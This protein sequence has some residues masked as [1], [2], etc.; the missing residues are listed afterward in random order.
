MKDQVFRKRI[1]I[2]VALIILVGILFVQKLVMIQLVHGGGYYEDADRQYRSIGGEDS[3]RGNIYASTKNGDR[4]SIATFE[5]GYKVAIIPSK[6]QDKE[7]LFEALNGMTPIER[8]KFI[9]RASKSE[10]PYEEILHRIDKETADRISAL[11]HPAVR[12]YRQKWRTYPL[13]KLAA[14]TIGF[15]AFEE[16]TLRGQYGLERFYQGTLTRSAKNLYTN[17]FAQ[18]FTDVRTLIAGSDIGEADVVTTLEPAVSQYLHDRIADIR[19][20]WRAEEVGGIIIRPRTGEIVALDTDPG[21]DLNE[22]ASVDDS[23]VYINPLTEHVYEMGSIMKPVIM[24]IGLET[25]VIEP[26]TLYFDNGVVEVEEY[27]IYNYDKLGRG[28]VSM[29]DIINKSLN[30][31]MVYLMSLM[32]KGKV[33]TYL[34]AFGLTEKTG[35][36]LPSEAAPLTSNLESTREIE[37]ANI[38]FGQGLAVTPLGMVRSLAT[39]ANGGYLVH[40]TILKELRYVNGARKEIALTDRVD[41]EAIISTQTYEEITRMLVSTVDKGLRQDPDPL[42][43]YSIAA[44]TGTAQIP[45]PATGGYH[46]DR[47]LHAFFGY[48]PAYQ[49]EFLVF[50]YVKYPKEV[51]Y[52]SETLTQPFMETAEFLVKYYNIL[53]DRIEALTGENALW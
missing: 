29:T 38:S 49:P 18:I 47:N 20:T 7:A 5:S 52:S 30:T 40:P 39:L 11:D 23:R 34:T 51:K 48:F 17:F 37:Y 42:R 44:K 6:I 28:W 43:G 33:Q 15:L 16:D 25:G 9:A 14:Q 12:V 1:R 3:V 32:D 4:V 26:D 41:T 8:D 36:D 35:I 50:L 21:F 13:G 45:N 24:A 46:D 27:E 19:T 53:P 22:F 31:G 10:D 2:G